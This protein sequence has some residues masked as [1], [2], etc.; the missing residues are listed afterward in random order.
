M[1]KIKIEEWLENN[2]GSGYGYGSGDGDDIVSF[3]GKAVYNI[4]GIRTIIEYI[5]DSI[6]KGYILNSDFSLTPCF[7]AKGRGYFAHGESLRESQQ[8]LHKKIFEN[9]DST[10]AI[11]EFLKK[12]N[13]DE[14]YPGTEFFEWHHYLTGSCL[15]GRKSFVNDRGLNIDDLYTVDEFI[16]ICEGAYGD[17]IIKQLKEKWNKKE[18]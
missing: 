2:F 3:G 8:A 5:K 17:Q 7:I 12:F 14:K 15:M 16:A 6:A 9:M 13:K 18:N 10:E 11:E 1:E 4:D